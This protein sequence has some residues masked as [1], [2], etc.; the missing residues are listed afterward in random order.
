[1]MHFN[2][3]VDLSSRFW[4]PSFLAMVWYCFPV[5]IDLEPRLPPFVFILRS[6]L[7]EQTLLL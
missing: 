1:M 4:S 2:F 5:V 3:V 6:N 7:R